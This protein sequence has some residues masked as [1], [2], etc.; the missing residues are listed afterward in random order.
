MH[1]KNRT[2]NDNKQKKKNQGKE[3]SMYETAKEKQT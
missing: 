1:G 3:E 2:P